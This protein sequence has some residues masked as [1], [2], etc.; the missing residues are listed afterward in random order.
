MLS[1][2]TLKSL[3]MSTF[4]YFC[5]QIC[6]ALIN[7][8][9]LSPL[10]LLKND[11][12]LANMQYHRHKDKVWYYQHKRSFLMWKIYLCAHM[13]KMEGIKH[14]KPCGHHCS[15][16][17][18]QYHMPKHS[19]WWRHSSQSLCCFCETNTWA[20]SRMLFLCAQVASQYSSGGGTTGIFPGV[21]C[22]A[23]NCS[24][25]SGARLSTS[26]YV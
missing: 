19:S 20:W 12:K 18:W 10:S 17:K 9:L 13:Y 25:C 21:K 16:R 23:R 7:A 8:T 1:Q 22:W 6:S 14:W 11:F 2:R 24:F 26:E 15:S 4:Q 3:G 5:S